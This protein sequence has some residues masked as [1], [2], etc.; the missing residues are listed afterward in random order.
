LVPR[1]HVA[2]WPFMHEDWPLVQL[3]W[4]PTMQAALG[5]NPEHDLLASQA[6][7][8]TAKHPSASFVHVA[9]VCA[10]MQTV[11]PWVQRVDL[12]LHAAVVPPSVV[13]TT[14]S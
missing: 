12:H 1:V 5:S 13:P 14:Q 6:A 7:V 10:S 4:Q 9:S 2:S 11:P 3:S 8:V